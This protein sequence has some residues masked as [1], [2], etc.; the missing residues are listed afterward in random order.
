MKATRSETITTLTPQ[1]IEVL[2][3]A[4]QSKKGRSAALSDPRALL[5]RHG[6]TIPDAYELRLY[7]YVKTKSDIARDDVADRLIDVNLMLQKVPEAFDASWRASHGGCPFPTVPY[8]T[9][10]KV[11]VC[12]VWSIFAGPK[13]WVQDV[14]GTPF[15][16]FTYPNAVEVCV[17]WHEVEVEVTECLPRLVLSPAP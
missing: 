9:K 10:R 11:R 7:E 4:C 14:P 5:A 15:G 8:K 13:E 1:A 17:R 3:R 12:D 6:F 2:Q 16:H